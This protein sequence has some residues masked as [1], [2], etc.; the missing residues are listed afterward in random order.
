MKRYGGFVSVV[1]LVIVGMLMITY[2]PAQ[3]GSSAASHA[4]ILT[5]SSHILIVGNANFTSANGVVS[6]NGTSIN[7]YVI[8]GLSI[9]FESGDGISIRKTSAYFVIRDVAVRNS[10]NGIIFYNVT[11]GRIEHSVLENNSFG[12]H[13]RGCIDCV[14]VNNTFIENYYGIFL[15]QCDVDD[16]ENVFINNHINVYREVKVDYWSD[17][18]TAST[19]AIVLFSFLTFI[20]LMLIYFRRKSMRERFD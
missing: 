7:P 8:E 5:P 14:V 1:A 15:W 10:S 4:T 19:V 13:L 18:M 6:G 9:E 20:I 2:A 16:T 11:N 3:I 17:V 12:V